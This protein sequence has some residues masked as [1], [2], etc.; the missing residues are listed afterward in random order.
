MRAI[1]ILVLFFL[2]VP[3]TRA[4][5]ADD[6]ARIHIEAIGGKLRMN[7]LR[8]LQA[9]GRV[10]IDGRVL[11]FRLLAE[12]P[13]RLRM[14]TRSGSRRII[15]ATDGV[16]APWQLDPDAKPGRVTQLEGEEAREFASDAE[17][18]DPLV[19]YAARGYSIDY[20]GETQVGDRRAIKLLVTRRLVDSFQ[21]MVDAET[22]F[23]LQKVS[24][25]VRQGRQVKMEITYDDHRPVAGIIIPHR[26]L[27]YADGRLLHETILESVEA[28]APVPPDS[29][30][31]PILITVP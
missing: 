24:V 28:N 18:D 3:V 10:N 17:F 5:S 11:T 12:R 23:I 29:F 19:D 20:A 13:N 2:L 9:A 7:L 25:R 6:V 30:T 21:L 22:Y 16:S 14:E 27:T 1:R 8:T 26:Y 15:Q 31:A 4:D